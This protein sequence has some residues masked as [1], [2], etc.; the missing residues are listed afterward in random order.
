MHLRTEF[1][2]TVDGTNGNTVLHPVRAILGDSAFEV[3]GAIARRR[4]RKT[5]NDFAR[6]AG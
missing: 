1:Q 4:A 5:Q 6:C 2:A 3:S